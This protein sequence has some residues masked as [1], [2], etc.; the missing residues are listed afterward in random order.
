MASLE[1]EL[2]QEVKDMGERQKH[3]AIRIQVSAFL[4]A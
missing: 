2:C 1:P 3:D 4:I